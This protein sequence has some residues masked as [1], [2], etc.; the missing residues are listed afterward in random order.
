[1]STAVRPIHRRA[2][3]SQLRRPSGRASAGPVQ[4]RYLRPAPECADPRPAVAFTVGRRAG[5][6]VT[7]N[8]I[9]RR[10]RAAIGQ[11]PTGTLRP[12]CY[13]VGAAAPAATL[14]YQALVGCLEQALTGA[15]R[16]AAAASAHPAR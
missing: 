1:M 11:V 15:T 4:V 10:L 9:R 3:F 14:S 6:A 7:R 5:K 13:L 16:V 8:R 12:G 2:T